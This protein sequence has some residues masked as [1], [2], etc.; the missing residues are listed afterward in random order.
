MPSHPFSIVGQGVYS[1]SDAA[2]LTGV[3]SR[4]VRRWVQ[5]YDFKHAGS[6]RHSGPVVRRDAEPADQTLWLSF[7]DLVEVRFIHAFRSSGV[8]WATIRV[9]A[10]RASELLHR[11]HPFSSRSFK[12]DGRSILTEI[13]RDSDAPELLDMVRNQLAFKKVLDPHLHSGFEF[14]PKDEVARWWHESGQKR[15]VIDPTRAFGKPIVAIEAVPTRVLFE[16]FR[17]EGTTDRVA[18][19]FEVSKASVSAAIAFERSLAA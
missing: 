6:V 15:V 1:F 14:G 9:A 3:P 19:I 4:R 17:A 11:D 7:A 5:G 12:T 18:A 2:R 8:S 10:E 13:A 16:A